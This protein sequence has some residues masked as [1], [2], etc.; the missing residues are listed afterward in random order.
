MAPST[1]FL[2]LLALIIA[3][4]LA[5]AG[6]RCPSIDDI[7]HGPSGQW[8]LNRL[9][10]KRTR[11]TTGTWPPQEWD[12]DEAEVTFQISSPFNNAGNITCT[13]RAVEFS[14]EYTRQLAGKEPTYRWWP[15]KGAK[16]DEGLLSTE[17]QLK[18]PRYR[19]HELGF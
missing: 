10:W 1:P 12:M 5:S 16:E 15:C 18:C 4:P 7:G 6:T 19:M 9:D 8:T 2:S 17:F 3:T 11:K 13:A 14:E